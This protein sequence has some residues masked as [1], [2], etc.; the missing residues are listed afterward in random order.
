MVGMQSKESL[1]LKQQRDAAV[2]ATCVPSVS[3]II[4]ARN[5]EATIATTLDSVLSQDYAGWVEVIVADGSDTPA[6]A[7][8]IRRHY[9]AVRL[10]P[11]P[12][13]TLG[14]G[15]NAALQVATGEIIVR[16]DG[17]T[18][19]SPGYIQCAV[20]TLAVTKAANVGGYQRPVG[21]TFFERVVAVAMTTPIGAGHAYHRVGGS[22]GPVDTAFLGNF[23]R[24]VLVKMGGYD[25]SLIRNQDYE[26]NWRLRERGETIWF[27][28]ALVADYRPRGTLWKL[29][30]QYF[31]YG[32]W[33][34]VVLRRHPASLQP[35]QLAAPLLVLGLAA[36]VFLALIGASW[37]ATV[38]LPFIYIFTLVVGSLVVG[39]C[40]R[41]PATLLLPLVLMTMHLSWGL[42]FFFPART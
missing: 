28:P 15:V 4:P 20:E 42:G 39:I 18:S 7:D 25:A 8:L 3:V 33:K 31:D 41:E 12:D 14:S 26:L 34:R 23:R 32:R 2:S 16:C 17:H 29:A 1:K 13:Q 9:P 38:T 10:I 22:E 19:L 21:T 27:N 5:A 36:S 40:R 30:R 11:N 6:T 37:F 35:R 24:E